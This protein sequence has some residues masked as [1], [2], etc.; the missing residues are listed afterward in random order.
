[1]GKNAHEER[2]Q[3][4]KVN[5][6]DKVKAP[7]EKR[8][9]V[10]AMYAYAGH[11]AGVAGVSGDQAGRRVSGMRT[12]GMGGHTG[13]D[14]AATDRG[15]VLACDRDAE[16]LERARENTTDAAFKIRYHKVSFRG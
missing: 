11:V 8:I 6:A 2:V 3:R 1:V 5:L 9:Q 16:S 7:R 15:L 12:A 4:A 14:R 10:A 13:G